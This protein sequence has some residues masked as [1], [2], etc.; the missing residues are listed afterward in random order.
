MSPASGDRVLQRRVPAAS[1]ESM[2]EFAAGAGHEINNPVATI[3]GRVQQLLRD[4]SDPERRRALRIIGGQAYRIRDMIGD[5]MLFARPPQPEPVQ[6]NLAAELSTSVKSLDDPDR[7]SGVSVQIDAGDSVPVFADPV[8]LQVVLTSL[9]R[10]SLEA[11]GGDGQIRASAQSANVEGRLTARLT[12]S[13]TGPGFSERDRIHLFDPFYSGRQAGRG[14]GFGLSKC[15][16]IVTMHG[17][18]IELDPE[19]P[20]TCVVVQ[21][22]AHE[23]ASSASA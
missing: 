4:E 5:A 11:V 19:S 12:I 10:N 13:D 6:L 17:G 22:P 23:P 15:W 18:T 16:R 14:L 20:R 2:A 9:L 8:Q 7:G 21:L 3:V 1:L